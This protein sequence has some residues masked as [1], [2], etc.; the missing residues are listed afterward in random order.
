MGKEGAGGGRVSR[1][2]AAGMKG[3][4]VTGGSGSFKQRNAL[5]LFTWSHY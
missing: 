5:T 4:E 3:A 2:M 1:A